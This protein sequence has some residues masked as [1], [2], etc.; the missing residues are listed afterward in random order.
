MH[1][2]AARVSSIGKARRQALRHFAEVFQEIVINL[3]GN[4]SRDSYLHAL[5]VHGVLHELICEWLESEKPPSIEL[6]VGTVISI[7]LGSARTAR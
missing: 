2:E 7:F 5:G 6:L 4:R 1:V 3:P